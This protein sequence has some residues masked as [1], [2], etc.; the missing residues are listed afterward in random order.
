MTKFPP[1]IASRPVSRQRKLQ[2]L[3]NREGKCMI[4]AQPLGDYKQVCNACSECRAKRNGNSM[5]KLEFKEF[6][7]RLLALQPGTVWEVPAWLTRPNNVN[8][9]IKKLAGT[10]T[11]RRDGDRFW[12][13]RLA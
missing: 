12:I 5:L 1:D 6:H 8:H 4:C 7:A 9:R 3:W 11:T 13:I 2:I 10:F